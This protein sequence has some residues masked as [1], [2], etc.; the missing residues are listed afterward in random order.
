MAGSALPICKVYGKILFC[1]GQMKFFFRGIVVAINTSMTKEAK[2]LFSIGTVER[3]TGIGRDTLRIWERRYGFPNPERNSKGERVYSAEQVR[4]LQLMRRLLDQ[5]LRPGKVVPLS[6]EALDE[7]AGTLPE[8]SSSPQTID[9]AHAELIAL[10][11]SGNIAA[12]TA[13]RPARVRP[14]YLRTLDYDGWGAVGRR[15]VADLR[16]APLDAA[17]GALPGCRHEPRRT[18]SG[19]S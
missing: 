4:R 11:S 12:L 7:L 13:A 17:L 9:P 8:V 3:D 10:A 2:T 6:E 1:L 15:A 14:Q 18:S 19:G 16:G 5:G